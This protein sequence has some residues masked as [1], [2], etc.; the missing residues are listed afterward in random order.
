M[1]LSVGQTPVCMHEGITSHAY[2]IVHIQYTGMTLIL[3]SHVHRL[4]E[5]NSICH[6]R[7]RYGK[8]IQPYHIQNYKNNLQRCRRI[9]N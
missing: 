3:L 7:D 6:Q 2:I 8:V 1:L 4:V 5:G 9:W